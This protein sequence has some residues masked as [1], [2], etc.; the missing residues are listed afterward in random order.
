MLYNIEKERLRAK[1]ASQI[2]TRL[3]RTFHK[4]LVVISQ[5]SKKIGFQE[6]VGNFF[7][8]ISEFLFF[9]YIYAVLIDTFDS[10]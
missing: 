7:S 5:L 4:S 9:V 2:S 8:Q 6:K 3:R 10:I 1:N